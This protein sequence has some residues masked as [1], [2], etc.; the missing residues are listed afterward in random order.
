M[1]GTAA[2]TYVPDAAGMASFENARVYPVTVLKAT[3]ANVVV[4]SLDAGSAK[5]E[6]TADEPALLQV[7]EGSVTVRL[8]G[9]AIALA[10][11][12]LLH[13]ERGVPH[14]IEASERARVQLTI[15]LVDSPGPSRIPEPSLRDN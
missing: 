13:I 10:P 6:H 7:I 1:R 8:Q 2:F 3:G 9:E 4:M 5:A 15:L 12:D 14:S 11:G